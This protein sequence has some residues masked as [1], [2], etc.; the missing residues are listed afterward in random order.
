MSLKTKR[1][2]AWLIVMFFFT[3]AGI[4]LWFKMKVDEQPTEHQEPE[5]PELD[6]DLPDPDEE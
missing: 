4:A 2:L 1:V 3:A 5:I 6:I